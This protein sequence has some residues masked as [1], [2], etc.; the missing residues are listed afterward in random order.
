[1]Q[2]F[3]NRGVLISWFAFPE[4]ACR[5]GEFNQ[6]LTESVDGDIRVSPFLVMS[7]IL[8]TRVSIAIDC[9]VRPTGNRAFCLIKGCND[10]KEKER[11][12]LG[13]YSTQSVSYVTLNLYRIRRH[14][15]MDAY[16]PPT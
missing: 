1:M 8:G 6:G 14:Q 10:G 7:R 4:F 5:Q 12:P 16:R 11:S 3:L 15:P 13:S 2:S 9:G